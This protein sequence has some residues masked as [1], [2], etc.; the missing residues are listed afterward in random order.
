[1]HWVTKALAQQHLEAL[2][3]VAAT[4]AGRQ[5]LQFFAA[6]RPGPPSSVTELLRQWEDKLHAS[7]AQADNIGE[8]LYLATRLASVQAA[9]EIR[10][11]QLSC[12][13][14]R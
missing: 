7:S 3:Q 11:A 9:G 10:Q 14:E 6:V 8:D 2:Q 12:R 4:E 13:A 1:L 5:L